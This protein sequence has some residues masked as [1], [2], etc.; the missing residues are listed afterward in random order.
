MTLITQAITLRFTLLSATLLARGIIYNLTV[1]L[2]FGYVA[3]ILGIILSFWFEY[4]YLFMPFLVYENPQLSFSKVYSQ[5]RQQ[6]KGQRLKGLVLFLSFFGWLLL[7][8]VAAG[9]I[10]LGLNMDS[11]LISSAIIILTLCPYIILSFT[12]FHKQCVRELH[13]KTCLTITS[14]DILKG[15]C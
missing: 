14:Q 2:L 10:E 15:Y 7:A 13:L 6:I 12:G 4:T 11:T 5:S 8:I 9:F 1:T 3:L